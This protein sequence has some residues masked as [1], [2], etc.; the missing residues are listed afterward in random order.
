MSAPEF[1]KPSVGDE[2][3]IYKQATRFQ[4]EQR[5]PVRVAA[6]AR[7]R[8]TVEG[9]DGEA[10]PWYLEEFDVRSQTIWDK[11]YHREG[12]ELHT[13]ETL[14]YKRLQS[15]VEAFY[16][17]HRIQT[18]HFRGALRKAIDA[19][20]VEFVNLLLRFAGEDEIK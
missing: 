15:K 19:D 8:I 9:A 14:A 17:E 2:L 4:P 1:T 16:R 5:I 18:Y 3:I 11:R 20:P 7:F 6:V 10:L 13:A 12:W